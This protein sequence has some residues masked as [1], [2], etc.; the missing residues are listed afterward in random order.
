MVKNIC[1]YWTLHNILWMIW[2]EPTRDL[3]N[4]CM[5]EHK[6]FTW[7]HITYHGIYRGLNPLK[8]TIYTFTRN[9]SHQNFIAKP[10]LS[11]TKYC[12]FGIKVD[13][14]PGTLKCNDF[15]SYQWQRPFEVIKNIQ[16]Y[17]DRFYS[18][19]TT[20][21]MS[22]NFSKSTAHIKLRLPPL[23]ATSFSKFSNPIFYTPFESDNPDDRGGTIHMEARNN[24]IYYK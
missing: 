6:I 1:S 10:H 17:H 15:E 7:C 18:L 3:K 22:Q 5:Y 21:E 12:N 23:L 4:K 2:V 8:N 19:L 24:Q 13:Q 20:V 9:P 16:S 14:S 11:S